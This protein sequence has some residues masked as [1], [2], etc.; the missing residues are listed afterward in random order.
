MCEAPKIQREILKE[1]LFIYSQKDPLKGEVCHF[2]HKTDCLFEQNCWAGHYNISA[3]N[4]MSLG[5]NYLCATEIAHF[6]CKMQKLINFI[7]LIIVHPGSDVISCDLRTSSLFAHH[8]TCHHHSITRPVLFCCSFIYFQFTIFMRFLNVA[9]KMLI[10]LFNNQRS[11]VA[12][13]MLHLYLYRH[14][15]ATK[16]CGFVSQQK[17]EVVLGRI[18]SEFELYSGQKLLHGLVNGGWDKFSF[19]CF[20]FIYLAPILNWF[21]HHIYIVAFSNQNP[22]SKVNLTWDNIAI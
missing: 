16:H 3:T 4:S 12:D 2:R 14:I 7:I 13:V 21:Q 15:Q 10:C 6:S 18:P 17:S 8:I 11:F 9:Q 20:L 1:N 22:M 5:W 19:W